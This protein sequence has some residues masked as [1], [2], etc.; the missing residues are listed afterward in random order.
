VGIIWIWICSVSA[1]ECVSFSQDVG[2]NAV[3][4]AGGMVGELPPGVDCRDGAVDR[5]E[6]S[7]VEGC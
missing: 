7:E 4:W 5:R 3:S 1:G 6:G 2:C